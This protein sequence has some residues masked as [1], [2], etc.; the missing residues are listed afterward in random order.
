[1]SNKR[2]F[3]ILLSGEGLTFFSINNRS[4][5]SVKKKKQNEAFWGVVF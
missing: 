2:S 3:I 4:N 1:M 5:L